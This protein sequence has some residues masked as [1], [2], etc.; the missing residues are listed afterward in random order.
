MA[1]R[2]EVELVN[3]AEVTIP[4]ADWETIRQYAAQLRQPR[5]EG[6]PVVLVLPPGT[7]ITFRQEPDERGR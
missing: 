6:K 4:D 2:D 3:H 5:H 7:R 1:A